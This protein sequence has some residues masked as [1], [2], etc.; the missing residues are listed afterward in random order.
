MRYSLNKVIECEYDAGKWIFVSDTTE[1]IP[2][3]KEQADSKF[4]QF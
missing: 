3:T 4:S 2:G 1:T